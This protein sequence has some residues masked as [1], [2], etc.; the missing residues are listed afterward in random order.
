MSTSPFVTAQRLPHCP[1][2][3]FAREEVALA[4]RNSG[5]PLELL[6]HDITPLG[7]HYLLTHF[8]IPYL[9][10]QGFSLDFK[11]AFANPFSLDLDAIR[12]LPRVTVPVTLECAG[13]GRAEHALRSRSMPWRHE[14]VGTAEWS[15]TPLYPLIEKAA[16]QAD[17]C[18]ISFIG[19]DRGFDK[20][21][22]H[23]FG[24]SLTLEQLKTLEVLLV[25]E[26]NGQ[27][28][29]P[30]HGAPLRIVVPGWY[31]MASVKWLTTIEAL[32]EP[33]TGHQ[34]VGTYR[35]RDTAD[36]SGEPVTG[37]RV[38]SLMVPPGIPDW[39]SRRRLVGAGLTRLEG[40]AWSGLGRQIVKV[41]VSTG[42]TWHEATLLPP[43]GTYAWRGWQFDW[44]ATPGAH[45]LRCRA[46]DD[47]GDFQP[48]EPPWD[49]AGFGNNMVQ[50]L[51]VQV[52]EIA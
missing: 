21:H 10:A 40:R 45:A 38:K 13:N 18:E 24:R 8:D 23:A 36:S 15:G 35:F 50:T 26:M 19:A 29:M 49:V 46:T 44:N 20:G 33:F 39:Y 12:A 30:Q 42:D 17:A 5:L 34:Q 43:V 27:P 22:A 28:L 7:A 4:N 48:L 31:G 25:T 41:E 32:T 16:P 1:T 11:G 14:A 52:A 51:E 6:R 3:E 47:A 37:I 2:S 9:P